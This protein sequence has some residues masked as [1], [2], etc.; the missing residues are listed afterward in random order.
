MFG[1]AVHRPYISARDIDSNKSD[2]T[3]TAMD[4]GL[5]SYNRTQVGNISNNFQNRNSMQKLLVQAFVNKDITKDKA[6]YL[7]KHK[8]QG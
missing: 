7:S 3:G 5:T 1:L 6:G 8:K 4:N 2:T